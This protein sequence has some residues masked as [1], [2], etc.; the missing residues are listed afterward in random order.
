ME[1]ASPKY[2]VG[3]DISDAVAKVAALC[4]NL[5]VEDEIV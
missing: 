5:I 2:V 3:H 4:Q 1:D